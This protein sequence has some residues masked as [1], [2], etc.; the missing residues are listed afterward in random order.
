MISK[1]L[2][3]VD[4]RDDHSWQCTLPLAV[5]Q[6]GVNGAELIVMTVFEPLGSNIPDLPLAEE[7]NRNALQLSKERLQT[8]VSQ[9]VPPE[10]TSQ[11][12]VSQGETVYKEILDAARALTANLIVMAAHRPSLHDYLLGSNASKVV[13]HADCSVFVVRD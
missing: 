4:L 1:I 3:P 13:R 12:L 11:S 9:Q 8:L 2:V 5:Q 7:H 6:A 10:V